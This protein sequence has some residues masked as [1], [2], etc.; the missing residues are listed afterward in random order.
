[1]YWKLKTQALE[2]TLLDITF[3]D[4]VQANVS[5]NTSTTFPT[6]GPSDRIDKSSSLD[7]SLLECPVKNLENINPDKADTFAAPKQ[8]FSAVAPLEETPNV[9]GA[10]GAHLNRENEPVE[11]VKKKNLI[12]R[13]SSFQ[14]SQKM[15]S[16]SSLTK[17]NPRKSLSMNKLKNSKSDLS[18]TSSAIEP[19][20]EKSDGYDVAKV[21]FGESVKVVHEETKITSQ[22]I[23]AIQQL[24][25]GGASLTRR[26][27]NH[28]WL[29]RCSRE[30][31]LDPMPYNPQR[32]SGGTSDSGVESMDTS[33]TPT[34]L[35]S[36]DVG[37][38]ENSPDSA[39]EE[40][41]ICPSDSEEE[42][43]SKR[44]RNFKKRLSDSA[45]ERSA[46]RQ[47]LDTE[48]GFPH[49]QPLPSIPTADVPRTQIIHEAPN[50]LPV[51]QTQS[52]INILSEKISP[53]EP[54]ISKADTENLPPVE[55][56]DSESDEKEEASAKKKKGR[57]TARATR[58]TRSTKAKSRDS[59]ESTRPKR[60]PAADRKRVTRRKSK[61]IEEPSDDE[62]IAETSAAPEIPIYGVEATQVVPRFALPTSASGDLVSDFTRSVVPGASS[63]SQVGAAAKPKG[64]LTDREKLEAKVAAGRVNE[65]FVRVNLKKKVFVRGK[66]N[67]N[68]SK[69]RKNQ[70]K[71]RKKDLSSSEAALDSADFAEKSGGACFKCGGTGHFARRCTAMK[72]DELLPID[73]D[74]PSDFLT[75]EEVERMAN[76]NLV[77]AHSSR[78]DRIP[79]RPS[80]SQ[81]AG[82]PKPS[83]GM[84][85]EVGDKDDEDYEALFEGTDFDVETEDNDETSTSQFQGHKIPEELLAKL[86]PPESG[87]VEPVY[88]SPS[89]TTIEQTPAEVFEALRMFGHEKFRPGQEKAV[90]RILSGQ[91]TLVTLSTG[92]GKSL[93]YQL[94]AYI[95]ARNSR[96]ITLVVSPLVSLM[97][98]Q[99]VGVPSFLSAAALHTGQTAST[100][101]KIMASIKEGKLDILLVSPEAVVA[102]EKSTGFG[103]LLRQL[104]PIAFAC[105]D[106]AHCISQ[107][108]HNFRP[109]YL[110]IC[111][112]LIE[113]LGVKTILGLTA[114]ATKSTAES[115]VKHLNI[116]DGM[117]GVISDTP[118]PK[119]LTLTVSKDE[120]RDR[121]L[122]ELLQSERFKECDSIIVYCTRREECTRIAGVLRVSLQASVHIII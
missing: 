87:V 79:E 16:S 45:C 84:D 52:Q 4:D 66:K 89:N 100:K 108:S 110:M 81:S 115:I 76:K 122:I 54:M 2:E 56:L 9:D 21:M 114:T 24:I 49:S 27:L 62:T 34:H 8:E 103:A 101:E 11:P 107:W 29:D 85:A 118:M 112:V 41:F 40:D 95:Y 50:A 1:M 74:E 44:V 116:R 3:S 93:C 42:S 31:N 19:D 36:P 38:A 78:M 28:G 6:E 120:L 96:C 119:N 57:K 73:G 70:W 64:S 14:L 13:S 121:A 97:D 51:Q 22:P 65:N 33:D 20:S 109:S 82:D 35:E 37:A 106:E 46:K 23:N 30:N 83:S 71:Q 61:Q 99:V 10:W 69:Y 117:D 59:R 7:K 77:M 25:K 94:P 55:K 32:L 98:D 39:N 72:S 26:T 60:T 75:L 68:F 86:L 80:F 43:R 15:F 102:G 47:R 92:S 91:S 5:A 105:I 58:T 113:K 111:R 63:S 12:G 88:P 67:F 53:I 17:R 104:P 18:S 90:M 48:D